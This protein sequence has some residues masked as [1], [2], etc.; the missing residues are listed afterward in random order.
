MKTARFAQV[1]Q[2]CGA[3]ETYLLWM[4]AA[5]DKLFQRAVKEHRIMTLHQE[6]RGAKKDFGTVGFHEEPNAQFIL[7]PKSLRRFGDRRII[8][9]DYE[10]FAKS[11]R[12]ASAPSRAVRPK[13]KPSGK[14]EAVNAEAH[15]VA[16]NVLKFVPPE[17]P[18]VPEPPDTPKIRTSRAKA[19]STRPKAKADPP[20]PPGST[21]K[22]L[23]TEMT[24]AMK[25]LRAGKSVAAYER[26]KALVKQLDSDAVS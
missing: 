20:P 17:P 19:T 18:D 24:K 6:L 8:A 16:E 4:P 23:I 13:P 11:S 1:V 25:E 14:K 22:R 15:P 26:L 21:N 9:I 10:L 3:P 7:F 12:A 5:E 2:A